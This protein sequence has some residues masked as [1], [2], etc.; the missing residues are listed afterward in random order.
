MKVSREGFIANSGNIILSKDDDGSDRLIFGSGFGYLGADVNNICRTRLDRLFESM[1]DYIGRL[2]PEALKAAVNDGS[3]MARRKYCVRPWT[4]TC[5]GVFEIQAAKTGCLIVATGHNTGGFSQSTSI[6]KA[7]L[8]AMRGDFHPMH[9]L[10][11]PKRF[12]SFW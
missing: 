9:Q 11:N 3:L 4:P 10:Y 8:A 7:A 1:Q 6:A 2:F 12:R 5:L